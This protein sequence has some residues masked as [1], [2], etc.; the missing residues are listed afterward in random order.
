[1]VPVVALGA[2]GGAGEMGRRLGLEGYNPIILIES[3]FPP[4]RSAA[5]AAPAVACRIVDMFSP[6]RTLGY[7]ELMDLM[8]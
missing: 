3:T 5:A 1:M 2:C 7:L 6:L 8:D 4:C